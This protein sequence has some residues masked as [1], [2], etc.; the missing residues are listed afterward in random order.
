LEL[1]FSI[2]KHN[3]YFCFANKVFMYPYLQF[4]LWGIHIYRF[5]AATREDQGFVAAVGELIQFVST[6]E[7]DRKST[8][9]TGIEAAAKS[10]RPFVPAFKSR[11]APPS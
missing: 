11:H 2:S 8:S 7:S 6:A 10:E 4:F 5:V 3:L 1:G 9:G